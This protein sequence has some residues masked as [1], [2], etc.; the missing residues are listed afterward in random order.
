MSAT[1]VALGLVIVWL[2][3]YRVGIGPPDKP[4]SAHAVRK[5]FTAPYQGSTAA[6]VSVPS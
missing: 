1:A 6:V 2:V 5:P 3:L 4:D